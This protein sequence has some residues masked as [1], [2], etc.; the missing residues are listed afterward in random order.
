MLS[1][2]CK[3]CRPLNLQFCAVL[4]SKF[5]GRALEGKLGITHQ[6]EIKMLEGCFFF[7][8]SGKGGIRLGGRL[9]TA[10][11]STVVCP[12]AGGPCR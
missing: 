9:D 6:V 11:N 10:S 1:L 8:L 4:L 7:P 12:A 3:G 5:K 2:F